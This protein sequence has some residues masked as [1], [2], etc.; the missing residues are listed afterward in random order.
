MY[1]P[2]ANPKQK[3]METTQEHEK[4]HCYWA[5]RLAGRLTHGG[6]LVASKHYSLPHNSS[7]WRT[8]GE[9]TLLSV[10]L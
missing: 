7:P 10:T 2:K 1:T 5:I 4:T 9:Q 8:D 6:E 3:R